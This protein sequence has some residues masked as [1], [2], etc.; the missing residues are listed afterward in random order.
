MQSLD[1][2]PSVCSPTRVYGPRLFA[3]PPPRRITSQVPF[4][5]LH[6]MSRKEIGKCD[7]LLTNYFETYMGP[8]N[9]ILH[10]GPIRK[11]KP[12]LAEV[13]RF[14]SNPP[15]RRSRVPAPCTSDLH[16]RS[17]RRASLIMN[18]LEAYRDLNK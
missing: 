2:K 9:R 5:S 15:P 16:K 12:C 14:A 6:A 1:R 13:V 3:T 18:Y 4:A 17:E 10:R 7:S 8:R 11:A